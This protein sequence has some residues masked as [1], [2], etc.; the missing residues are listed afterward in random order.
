MSLLHV[1]PLSPHF[2]SSLSTMSLKKEYKMPPKISRYGKNSKLLCFGVKMFT[3]SSSA[4]GGCFHREW[5]PGEHVVLMLS[6]SCSVFTFRASARNVW[7][8]SVTF[9]AQGTP[10]VTPRR[11]VTFNEFIFVESCFLVL[12]MLRRTLSDHSVSVEWK[13]VFHKI[14]AALHFKKTPIV[15]RPTVRAMCR[16]TN[17]HWDEE[18]KLSF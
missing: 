7:R 8:C 11:G 3:L 12:Q 15:C 18:K 13:H 16:N 17:K 6:T 10:N 4:A 14:S 2:L 1:V 9:H 5:L